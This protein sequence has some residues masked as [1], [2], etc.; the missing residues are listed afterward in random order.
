M[1]VSAKVDELLKQ[2]QICVLATTG[3]GD[4]PHAIPMWYL[5]QDGKNHHYHFPCFAKV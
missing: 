4:A 3:P 1:V 5:Y 2:T